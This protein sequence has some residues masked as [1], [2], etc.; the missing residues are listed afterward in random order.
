M[1]NPIIDAICNICEKELIGYT[2][3]EIAQFIKANGI[4][5]SAVGL[6]RLTKT[7]HKFD[8]INEDMLS[9]VREY[10]RKMQMN[11]Q[12]SYYGSFCKSLIKTEKFDKLELVCSAILVEIKPKPFRFDASMKAENLATLEKEWKLKEQEQYVRLYFE[13]IEVVVSNLGLKVPTY[14]SDMFDDFKKLRTTLNE[15]ELGYAF[16]CYCLKREKIEE[17]L[18][19][20]DNE[21]EKGTSFMYDCLLQA[22]LSNF[23]AL[24]DLSEKMLD[25]TV[26]KNR[27]TLET[28]QIMKSLTVFKKSSR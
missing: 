20:L 3:V 22:L 23:N 11:M 28:N 21:S 26:L 18:T 9:F 5:I 1:S 7:W 13:L 2:F 14:L 16:V 6:E 27:I 24:E 17:L 8:I 4:R 12:T 25:T 10:C 15:K 19:Q